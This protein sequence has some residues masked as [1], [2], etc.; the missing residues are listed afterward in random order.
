MS[1]A[2]RGEHA[3]SPHRRHEARQQG[4]VPRSAEFV[5]AMVYASTGGMVLLYGPTWFTQIR[6]RLRQQLT[7]ASGPMTDPLYH[8]QHTLVQLGWWLLPWLLV[9]VVAAIVGHWVQHGP[10]W[11]PHRLQPDWGRLSPGRGVQRLLRPQGLATFFLSV[12]KISILGGLVAWLV[13]Q[14]WDIL[15][16]LSSGAFE[17]SVHAGTTLLGRCAACLGIGLLIWGG[18]DFAWQL[19]QHERDLQMTPEELREEVK[20]VHND[21]SAARQRRQSAR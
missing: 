10:L 19:F 13:F 7:A 5:F 20:A 21:V 14:Q 2:D 9:I 18:V 6:E 11:L 4:R 8:L 17:D 16:Q 3:A 15:M 1:D 12:S